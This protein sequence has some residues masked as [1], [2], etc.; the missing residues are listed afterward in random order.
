MDII[1]V[2]L[3]RVGWRLTQELSN[4]N[5]NVTVVDLKEK[6]IDRVVETF[7]VQGF[8]GNGTLIETLNTVGI[9][10]CDLFISVTPHDENNILACLIANRMG[11]KN[12][13]ARVRNPEFLV[14]SE[15]MREELG[16]SLMIN[17]EYSTALEI[18]RL[19]QFPAAMDVESFSN[20]RIDMAEIKIKKE[21]PLC[22]MKISN[23]P[24]GYSEDLLICAVC[25]GEEVYIPNGNFV[26]REGDRIHVTGSHKQLGKIAKILSGKKEK[27]IKSVMLIGATRISV[28]LANMLI[29]AGKSVTVVEK[30]EDRG[31]AFIDHCP[32]ASVVLSDENDHDILL[33]EG[34]D[35]VDAVI[36][37]SNADETNI[38]VSLFAESLGVEK[39]ITKVNDPGISPLVTQL[40]NSS[41]V[42]IAET[43]ADI[44][45]QYVR[46]KKNTNSSH[47]K[48]LYKLVGGKIEA[49][50]F[51][52]EDYFKYLGKPLSTIKMKD[53]VLIA[54]V[55]RGNKIFFPSGNDT[56]EKGDIVIVVSKDYAMS[57]LNDIVK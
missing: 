31:K 14:Q 10:S 39:I 46:A 44:L 21:S 9:K 27:I 51:T 56:I 49:A 50:E 30:D 3:G 29:N 55:N 2:G 40:S 7:D 41:S 20:G 25:R 42:N 34:I 33:E 18:F 35:K 52:A 6:K 47:M 45:V 15:F 8:A 36:T 16:I 4:E 19:I 37:L 28:Y 17:P 54:A 13:V 48:T 5:H 11:V 24:A 1:I 32:K 43:T 38:L 23:I 57:N 12:T 26:I 22:N 53:D